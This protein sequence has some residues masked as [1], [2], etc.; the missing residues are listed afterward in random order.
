VKTFCLGVC[1]VALAVGSLAAQSALT[2]KDREEIKQLSASYARSLG[3]CQAEAYADLFTT[4]GIF[5]SGFRGNIQGRAALIALVKSERQC[6]PGAERPAR[7]GGGS[8]APALQFSEIASRPGGAFATV[9][10]PN[11][12]GNYEDTYAKTAAGWRFLNRSHYPP[13]EVAARAKGTFGISP[14][15]VLD[16]QQLVARYP[17]TLDNGSEGGKALADLFTDDGVFVT[18]QATFAGRDALL[19]MASGHRPGQGPAY[20]RNFAAN[21]RVEPMPDGNAKGKVYA[22]VIA[23]GENDQP[24]SVFTGG[25]FEDVYAKTQAGWRFKRRQFVPSQGGPTTNVGKPTAP[26]TR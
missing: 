22:V 7:P 13:A 25:H 26:A 20:V 14:Q 23:I 5:Y 21:V 6:Q 12:G 3:S 4:D 19:K 8:G 16:I 24:S 2:D 10:L 18:P 17:Y 11:N 15:D 1:G 9:T